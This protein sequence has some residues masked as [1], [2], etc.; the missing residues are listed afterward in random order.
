MR[1][2]PYTNLLPL[3]RLPLHLW[4]QQTVACIRPDG[5]W[6]YETLLLI[7][8]GHGDYD[9]AEF[10]RQAS[11]FVE[12]EDGTDLRLLDNSQVFYDADQHIRRSLAEEGVLVRGLDQLTL[13]CSQPAP[14]APVTL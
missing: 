6:A 4:V 8:N 14:A 1:L 12:R 3:E 11:A 5:T 9:V 2:L 10:A 13:T 7:A